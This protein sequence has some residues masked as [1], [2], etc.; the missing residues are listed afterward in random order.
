MAGHNNNRIKQTSLFDRK[1]KQDLSISTP[2]DIYLYPDLQK[3]VG[4]VCRGAG[5]V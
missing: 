3:S 1:K 5:I 4:G 2:L